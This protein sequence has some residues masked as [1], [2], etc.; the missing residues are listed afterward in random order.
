MFYTAKSRV[1]NRGFAKPISVS[2]SC[3]T[4]RF[5]IKPYGEVGLHCQPTLRSFGFLLLNLL[6]DC[7][8]SV[9]SNSYSNQF[10]RLF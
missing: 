5:G 1:P 2:A 4:T 6:I 7:I 10:I 8:L 9:Y 3:Q